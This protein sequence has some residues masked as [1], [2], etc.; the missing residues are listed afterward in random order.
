MIRADSTAWPPTASRPVQPTHLPTDGARPTGVANA[1]AGAYAFRLLLDRGTPLAFG[2]DA[3]VAP[4]NPLLGIHAA[5]TR[6]DVTNQPA[7]GLVRG[8]RLTVPRLS[9]AATLGPARLSGKSAT[10]LFD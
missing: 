9:R 10:V 5:V 4:L 8:E 3:P 1:F 6:Q 2:S 7:G